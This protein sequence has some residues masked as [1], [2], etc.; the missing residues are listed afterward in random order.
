MLDHLNRL[1]AEL[2]FRV[3]SSAAG[4]ERATAIQEAA[5]QI[6]GALATLC[7]ERKNEVEAHKDSGRIIRFSSI[8]PLVGTAVHYSRSPFASYED[9][10]SLF[11]TFQLVTVE[12]F[13]LGR[14]WGG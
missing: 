9:S 8:G 13:S 5:N 11:E 2:H 1:L 3:S 6:Y 7:S 4:S 14:P 10:P 12:R